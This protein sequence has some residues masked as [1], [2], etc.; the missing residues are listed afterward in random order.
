MSKEL[1]TPNLSPS[2]FI[3]LGSTGLDILSRFQ[4]LVLEH[5]G[6]ATLPIFSYVAIETDEKANAR[7]LDWGGNE[8]RLLTP[9]IRSTDAIRNALSGGH[10]EYLREWLNSDLLQIPGG[11]FTEGASNLRMA[12][13]L[14]L[15]ENWDMISSALSE[16]HK[17]ITSQSNINETEAYLQSRY[18]KYGVV[19]DEKKP[20]VDD[21]KPNVYVLGTLCGGSCSGMF[22]DV[23]YFIK[24]ISGLF[25]KSLADP[26]LAKVMGIFTGFDSAA[27]NSAQQESVKG[28]A[29]NSWAALQEFD[30][31]CH[32][33]TRYRTI[34][35]DGK[36][37]DTNE[38]PL[39][40]IYFLSHSAT[41]PGNKLKSNF[42]RGAIADTESLN[43]MAAMV[44][45]TETVG[46]LA[47]LKGSIR[48]DYRARP[49]AMRTNAS[50][51]SP[52]VATCGMAAVWYPRYRIALGAT[53]V[54][55]ASFLCRQWL[56][57]P[58]VDEQASLG[59]LVSE[60]WE[61]LFARHIDKLISM[62]AADVTRSSRLDGMATTESGRQGT[63]LTDD[64]AQRLGAKKD[65]ILE[66]V[67]PEF[68][69]ELQEL[70]QLLN[71]GNKY[72]REINNKDRKAR[73]YESLRKG[74]ND[75]IRNVLNQT[76]S[77]AF[78]RHAL[79]EIDREIREKIDMLPVSYPVP[80]PDRFQK[81][82]ADLFGKLAF[83]SA[84]LVQ[85][86]K[87]DVIAELGH[88]MVSHIKHIRNWA[89]VEVLE[90]I[91]RELGVEME[92]SAED[93]KAERLTVSDYLD[94]VHESVQQC[95]NALQKRE[96]EVRARMKETQ[97][98][99][100]VCSG[101]DNNI[102]EDIDR[103][104]AKLAQLPHEDAVELERDILGGNEL[105]EFL[106]FGSPEGRGRVIEERILEHVSGYLLRSD[107]E[108]DVLKHV[109]ST[110]RAAELASFAK[111]A[112]PHLE[113]TKG[114]SNLASIEIGRPVSFV[115]GGDIAV[116]EQMISEKLKGTEIEGAFGPNEKS[117]IAVREMTHMLLFYREE[118][119]MYIDDNM[120]TSQLFERYYEELNTPGSYGL[121]IHRGGRSV[122]DPQIYARVDEARKILM[123][124]ATNILSKGN[125]TDQWVSSE[126]FSIEYGEL[127]LRGE[128]KNGLRYRL[129]GD[130]TGVDFCGQESELFDQLKDSV[131]DKIERMSR[132]QVV[133]R[134]NEYLDRVERQ[135]VEDGADAA[136]ARGEAQTRMLAIG[137]VGKKV[138]I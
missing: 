65:T 67:L 61:D 3:A 1:F 48:T 112:L 100:V 120:A 104:A 62:T 34:F 73:F 63:L 77:V 103:L 12:G 106:G 13:R 102:S 75:L 60:I 53:C 23:A 46:G 76:Q 69:E 121:H 126:V 86:Y 136:K 88:Y 56:N 16:A 49:R 137:I 54:H 32:P 18:A 50:Q 31:Y 114:H 40:W 8:I 15:W 115:A 94:K 107:Q 36:S 119:Q 101:K 138:N 129:P 2:L 105:S 95:M 108:F 42:R 132:E 7:P 113:L 127:V 19:T 37:L 133:E 43:H 6:E 85:E 123:P 109:M 64:F 124:V 116:V 81:I 11:Q 28:H 79:R 59:R 92:H 110:W 39:D 99:R 97:D 21:K 33:Q 96:R 70:L 24:E 25:A 78:A 135:A 47:S 35:P 84:A 93:K 83:R 130:E 68:G 44:A 131:Y 30:F 118:P 71:E 22:I 125:E 5:Y 52:C 9:V 74:I 29:A 90:V 87:S 128:R 41:D 72:E 51:H 10:K 20:I 17:S 134:L 111:H 89:A 98:V 27:L 66:M 122:F 80:N 58:N 117:P 38:P 14:I 55:G 45:F 57:N 4:E 82:Q 26:A 91:R